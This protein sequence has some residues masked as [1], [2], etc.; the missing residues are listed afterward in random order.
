MSTLFPKLT[1]YED[2]ASTKLQIGRHSR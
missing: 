2:I 1:N